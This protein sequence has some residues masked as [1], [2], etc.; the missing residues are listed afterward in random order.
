MKTHKGNVGKIMYD[1]GKITFETLEKFNHRYFQNKGNRRGLGFDKPQLDEREKATC[2]C[3]SMHSFG[4]SGYTGTYTFVDPE[5]QIVYVFL[6]NRVYPTRE[7]TKLAT[8][9][10][11]PEVQRL[12]QEA[13]I[14]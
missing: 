12:I 5:T 14:E 13:I 6:S 8:N 7:N 1:V 9:N 4:H 10:I 2:G 3:V 11:R